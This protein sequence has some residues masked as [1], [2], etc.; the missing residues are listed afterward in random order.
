MEDANGPTDSNAS[1]ERSGPP[2]EDP[3][4]E[5]WFQKIWQTIVLGVSRPDE[6]FKGMRTTGGLL[7]PLLFYSIIIGPSILIGLVLESPFQVMTGTPFGEQIVLLIVFLL[8][9][10][11]LLPLGLFITSGLTH[12]GLLM[13]GCANRPFEATFR[14]NAYAYASVGWIHLLPICG[15]FIAAVWGIVLEIMGIARVQEISTGKA[16]AAVLVPIAILFV[17]FACI[18]GAFALTVHA[19]IS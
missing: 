3:Q 12:L 14:V 18:F 17:L 8:L 4:I 16:A 7:Q 6:L 15:S 2:W 9:L 10:P 5:D 13:F 19:A 11:L 1:F